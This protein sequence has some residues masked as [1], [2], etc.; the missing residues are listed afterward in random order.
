MWN[1]TVKASLAGI[2][3]VTGNEEM[4]KPKQTWKWENYC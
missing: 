4:I 3:S 2:F 1:V